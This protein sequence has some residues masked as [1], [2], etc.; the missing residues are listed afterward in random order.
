MQYIMLAVLIM[1]LAGCID[2]STELQPVNP[3]VQA[4]LFGS[5]CVP[6]V[7]GFGAG[8]NRFEAALQ[9]G[10]LPEEQSEP[11]YTPKTIRHVRSV[12]FSERA[13]LGFGD[14]CLDITGAP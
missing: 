13:F 8:T 5:D 3:D 2:I 11:R 6:I 9:N 4:A 12:M 10:R 7:L 14:R 1:E